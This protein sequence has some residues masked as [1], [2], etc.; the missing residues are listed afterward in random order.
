MAS[1]LNNGGTGY[2]SMLPN[3]LRNVL[4]NAK[5][6]TAR[7][8]NGTT[9][10]TST[11]KIFLPATKE[12]F[13][14][15]ATSAGSGTSYSN[16]TEFNALEQWEYYKTSANRIKKQGSSGSAYYWWERSPRCSDST[17]FCGVYSDGGADYSS[18]SASFGVAPAVLI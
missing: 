15:T 7:T 6:I 8:Y 13:G 5:V 9:N 16:L 3:W 12:V 18:A 4:L 2:L 11:H 17:R 14:G 1:F 10:Q